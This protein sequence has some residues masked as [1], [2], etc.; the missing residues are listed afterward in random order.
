MLILWR[1]FILRTSLNTAFR[2]DLA[3]IYRINFLNGFN[4][5]FSKLFYKFQLKH[6]VDKNVCSAT[7]QSKTKWS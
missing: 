2:H 3:L 7:Q 6:R 5:V 4:S 1:R